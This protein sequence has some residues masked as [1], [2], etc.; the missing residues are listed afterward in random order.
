M[1]KKIKSFLCIMF[2]AVLMLSTSV[3]AIENIENQSEEEKIEASIITTDLKDSI[4]RSKLNALLAGSSEPLES[5]FDLREVIGSAVRVKNQ[6]KIGSCWAISYTSMLETTM[7]R[8]YD[9]F[10]LEYSPMHLEYKST[11][12]FNRNLNAGGEM[13]IAIP[14]SA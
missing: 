9:R 5:R 14:Y 8:K 13:Q 10:D 4:K 3:Y 6:K 2:I 11:Q 1:N 7:A 12:I